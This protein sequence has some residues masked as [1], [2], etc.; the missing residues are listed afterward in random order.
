MAHR[1]VIVTGGFQGSGKARV[2]VLINNAGMSMNRSIEE[3]TV[4][5]GIR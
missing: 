2:D 4:M 3:L 1:L 5:S